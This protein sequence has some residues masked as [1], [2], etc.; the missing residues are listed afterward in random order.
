MRLMHF[1]CQNRIK[2]RLTIFLAISIP[3]SRVYVIK[4]TSKFQH[5][6]F[7]ISQDTTHSNVIKFTTLSL[8]NL[9][10]C[11]EVYFENLSR[12]LAR[13]PNRERL[14]ASRL[15]SRLRR[16]IVLEIVE[17]TEMYTI[18]HL[19]SWGTPLHKVKKKMSPLGSWS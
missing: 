17:S 18:P 13:N 4:K 9:S 7:F 5:I 11:L 1:F 2:C 6:D 3:K 14:R 8:S 10:D 12:V 16:T 19:V 15:A